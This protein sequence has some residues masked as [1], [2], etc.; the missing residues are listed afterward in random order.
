MGSWLQNLGF[1]IV[2]GNWWQ[3]QGYETVE[4]DWGYKKVRG[5]L[6][7]GLEGGGGGQLV[8]FRLRMTLGTQ[9]PLQGTI[10]SV[11]RTTLNHTVI[12]EN[13][14]IKQVFI[15]KAKQL[16]QEIWNCFPL[17]CFTVLRLSYSFKVIFI[18]KP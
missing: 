15:V 5:R 3:D 1:Q 2:E 9:Y 17:C 14:V 8:E 16:F 13:V 4:G 12:V 6:V 7:A 10:R 18:Q 11:D